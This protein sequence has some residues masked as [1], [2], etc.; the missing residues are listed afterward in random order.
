MCANKWSLQYTILAVISGR[1]SVRKATIGTEINVHKTECAK[2][3]GAKFR[4]K[5]LRDSISLENSA[6]KRSFRTY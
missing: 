4:R 6:R 3:C 5:K 2:H 1:L